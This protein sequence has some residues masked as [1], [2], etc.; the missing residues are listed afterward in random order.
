MRVKVND[1]NQV[2]EQKKNESKV[3]VEILE[4]NCVMVS[5]N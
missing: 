1:K 4:E 3:G 5:D 2:N